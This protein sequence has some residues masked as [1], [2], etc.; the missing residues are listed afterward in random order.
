MWFSYITS[1]AT[2]HATLK[3]MAM[4]LNYSCYCNKYVN[5]SQCT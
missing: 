3:Q 1:T 2:A 4:Q 5:Q